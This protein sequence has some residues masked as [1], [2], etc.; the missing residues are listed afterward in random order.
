M[1]LRIPETTPRSEL[2][3]RGTPWYRFSRNL[4][5]GLAGAAFFGMYI[6]AFATPLANAIYAQNWQPTPCTIRESSLQE[7]K[8]DEGSIHYS[9]ALKYRYYVKSANG[10]SAPDYWE[11]TRY[12]FQSGTDALRIYTDELATSLRPGDD[13]TCY[14]DPTDPS[15]AALNVSLWRPLLIAFLWSPLAA[16]PLAL[17]WLWW[18][19]RKHH[20]ARWRSQK[21]RTTTA[22]AASKPS[23]SQSPL[24]GGDTVADRFH[25]ILLGVFLVAGFGIAACG[26]ISHPF[27]AN[28]ITEFGW[29]TLPFGVLLGLISVFV[30]FGVLADLFAPRL[31]VELDRTKVLLGQTAR[32]SYRVKGK[33]ALTSTAQVVL[34]C[35]YVVPGSEDNPD[36][37]FPLYELPLQELDG[38]FPGG[39]G[40]CLVPIPID[41]PCSLK[42]EFAR[43]EWEIR[44]EL[45]PFHSHGRSVSLVFPVE[46]E[47]FRLQATQSP[48]NIDRHNPPSQLALQLDPSAPGVLSGNLLWNLTEPVSS[49]DLRLYWYIETQSKS[50]PIVPAAATTVSATASAGRAP[51]TLQ[52]PT[53]PKPYQSDKI[54]VV[55]AIEAVAQPSGIVSRVDLVLAEPTPVS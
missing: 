39:E 19:E 14:V 25:P 34:R 15:E 8:D 48:T 40:S 42:G 47:P 11:G 49:I 50:H 28:R 20:V 22:R 17:P 43:I 30:V 26:L 45:A 41:G 24:K 1:P 37:R 32:L 6:V 18:Y 31:L 29:I 12:N 36:E 7:Y 35:N 21:L 27:S 16:I 55:W 10:D 23:G 4:F 38:S 54:T 13:C 51:F 5:I 52:I 46:S 33:P 53:T 44:V 3:D 9:L 2:E